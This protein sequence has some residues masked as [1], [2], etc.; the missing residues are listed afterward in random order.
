MGQK[1]TPSQHS[2]ILPWAKAV[3]VCVEAEDARCFRQESA[4]P[5]KK[6]GEYVC[7]HVSALGKSAQWSHK[8]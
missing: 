5:N 2:M 8:L 3:H 6:R 1:V 7:T 4:I